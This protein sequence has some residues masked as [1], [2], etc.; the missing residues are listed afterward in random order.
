MNKTNKKLENNKAKTNI[1]SE[2]VW[3]SIEQMADF[4]TN[5]T[6]QYTLLIT[7]NIENKVK[8]LN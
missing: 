1:T 8:K 7:K 4:F 2:T 5:Q 6:N 3:P